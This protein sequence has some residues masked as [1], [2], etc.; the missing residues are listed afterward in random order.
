VRELTPGD[1]PTAAPSAPS[2]WVATLTPAGTTGASPSSTPALSTASLPDAADIVG[3]PGASG[4]AGAVGP[5]GSAPARNGMRY[6]VQFTADEAYVELLEQARDLLAH[7]IPDRDLARVQQL[8]LEALIEKLRRR[9]YAAT[10]KPRRARPD[11]MQHTGAPVLKHPLSCNAVHTQAASASMP[12]VAEASTGSS[13][14][15]SGR[16]DSETAHAIHAP[17]PAA[18]QLITGELESSVTSP[19]RETQT[20]H[21][22]HLPAALRRAVWERD[23]ARCTYVDARGVRCAETAKLEFH[24]EHAYA[25]GGLPSLDNIKLRCRPHND[26]AAERDFGRAFI[27][28]KRQGVSARQVVTREGHG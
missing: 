16:R 27:E 8:A 9:K 26:L 5:H 24:H 18:A 11:P 23:G 3:S 7:Q 22:R 25:L 12:S 4:P 10:D 28:G 15:L 6:K 17:T 2:D 1:G 20:P 19:Q 21:S 13:S 14:P